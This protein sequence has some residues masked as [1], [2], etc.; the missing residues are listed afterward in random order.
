MGI[1]YVTPDCYG[2]KTGYCNYING[3]KAEPI[4]HMVVL[5]SLIMFSVQTLSILTDDSAPAMVRAHVSFMHNSTHPFIPLKEHAACIP[6]SHFPH[7]LGGLHHSRYRGVASCNSGRAR[8][9]SSVPII[10]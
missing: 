6:G 10:G 2:L 1:A 5:G 8:N 9:N 3:S 4:S 7:H